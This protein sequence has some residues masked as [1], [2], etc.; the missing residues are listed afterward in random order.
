MGGRGRVA[1]F[2]AC[3]EMLERRNV[4][5]RACPRSKPLPVP[6]YHSYTRGGRDNP[7]SPPDEIAGAGGPTRPPGNSLSAYRRL[8]GQRP[9][10][11]GASLPWP[12]C[13]HL[14]VSPAHG[15]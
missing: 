6:S 8:E 5:S 9:S 3:G 15:D 1:G 14:G 13:P 12:G 10:K 4:S 11:T 2:F 7:C